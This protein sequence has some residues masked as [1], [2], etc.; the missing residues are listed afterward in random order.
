MART[1]KNSLREILA[2]S[3]RIRDRRAALGSFA[4]RK[5][6]G[7]L[8]WFFLGLNLIFRIYD[9]YFENRSPFIILPLALKMQIDYE[10]DI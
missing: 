1:D 5:G 2:P 6:G 9:K 10:R 4:Q 7:K 3:E 8:T